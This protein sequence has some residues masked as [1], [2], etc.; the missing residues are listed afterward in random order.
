M[1]RANDLTGMTFNRLTVIREA[2]T[3]V[4]KKNHHVK[5]L[6]KCECGN[7]TEV[8]SSALKSGRVGSCGCYHSDRVIETHTKHGLSNTRIKSIYSGMIQRCYNPNA[9]RYDRYGARGIKICDEWLGENGLVNFNEWAIQNGYSDELTID[10]ID[11]DKNYSPN[12][13]RWATIDIQNNNKSTSHFVTIDGEKHTLAE[14]GIINGIKKSTIIS[15][16]KLGWSE[17]D[18]V[19]VKPSERRKAKA[20]SGYRNIIISDKSDNTKGYYVAFT[21]NKKRYGKSFCTLE[22]ALKYR[23][24]NVE[25][26]PN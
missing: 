9:P 17:E 26:I 12:N 21:K 25:V 6:C 1:A 10:R 5:W 7:Y 4:H 16:I 14:W 23:D 22:E 24:E 18:A 13:C 19:T 3:S 2:D 11:N 8:V 15:R 20:K